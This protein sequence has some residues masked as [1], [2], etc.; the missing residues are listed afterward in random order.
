MIRLHNLRPRPGARHRVKR[1]GCGESSG[2]GKTSGKGHKGQKARSGGSIRIGFEGGQ[3]PLIRRLPKRGFNNAAFHKR[4]AIVNLDDLKGFS[5]G[6][7]VNEQSLRESN[8][9]RGDFDGLKI[10]GEGELKH[11]LRIEADKVSAS[12]REKIE[13]A[14]GTVTLRDRRTRVG[15]RVKQDVDLAPVAAPAEA[16]EENAIARSRVKRAANGRAKSQKSSRK[17]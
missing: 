4:Y 10:L 8:L 14:G 15:A 13:K 17:K 12:A 7:T 2:H 5:A 6:A 1:L 11:G 3:M 16:A 9:V